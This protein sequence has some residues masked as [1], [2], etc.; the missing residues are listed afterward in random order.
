MIV[1]CYGCGGKGTEIFEGKKLPCTDCDG[2]GSAERV[3]DCKKFVSEQERE[4]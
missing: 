3:D 4:Q 1:N 2:R